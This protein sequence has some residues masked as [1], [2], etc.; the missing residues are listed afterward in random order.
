MNSKDRKRIASLLGAIATDDRLS[1]ISHGIKLVGTHPKI[2]SEMDDNAKQWWGFLKRKAEQ[3]LPLLLACLCLAPVTKKG[4]QTLMDLARS[5]YA[6]PARKAIIGSV[7]TIGPASII[8]PLPPT[9]TPA[10]RLRAPAASVAPSPLYLVW[11]SEPI[12]PQ[13]ETGIFV[14]TNKPSGRMTNR[15]ATWL[16]SS[17]LARVLVWTQYGSNRVPTLTNRVQIAGQT[18]VMFRAGEGWKP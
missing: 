17:P 9:N 15:W 18:N 12:N 7:G 3:V 4:A 5:K 2:V 13:I 8:P 10:P 1:V 16:E 11:Q 6:T 14:A